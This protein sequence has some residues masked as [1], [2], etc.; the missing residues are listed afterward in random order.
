MSHLRFGT[1]PINLPYLITEP[2]F[3][4][5]H[6]QSY[7]HE[8]D[9]LRGIKKG[10]TFLL[11]CTWSPE[12]LN[13]HLPAKLRRQIAEKELNFYI[14]NAAKIAAEIGLGGRINMVTQAAFFKL[15]E[16][17]PVD[18]AIKYL[19]ESVVTSYGKKVKTSLT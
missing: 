16:I 6:R 19:K 11:N 12:E 15:T 5:C 10:G 4:A 13:E 9:L 1:N 7:V 17:I 14:I 3:V 2:Q 18:D 8:Y